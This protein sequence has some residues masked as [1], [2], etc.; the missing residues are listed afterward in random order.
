[1]IVTGF[2]ASLP[3]PVENVVATALSPTS[4]RLDWTSVEPNATH[5]VVT[6]VSPTQGAPEIEYFP[7][8]VVAGLQMTTTYCFDVR[9][10]VNS[11]LSSAVNV[12]GTTLAP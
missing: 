11:R 12:C 4:L 8:H 9:T 5:Y 1:V 6:R 3:L 2:S 10:A 7:T